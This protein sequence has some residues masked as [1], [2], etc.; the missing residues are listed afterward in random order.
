MLPPV[1]ARIALVLCLASAGILIAHHASRVGGFTWSATEA[2]DR[3]HLGADKA[4]ALVGGAA[5]LKAFAATAFS[6][7]VV[8]VVVEGRRRLKGEKASSVLL[9]AG[10]AS[11]AW[12]VFESMERLVA[13]PDACTGLR[14]AG[15]GPWWQLAI[16]GGAT[17]MLLSHGIMVLLWPVEMGR[18]HRRD[19]RGR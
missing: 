14:C 13:G 8:A 10:G 16:A 3:W 19:H 9:L 7:Y 2:P 12:A 1:H 17:W 18:I 11:L 15:V 4:I 5:T 6:I